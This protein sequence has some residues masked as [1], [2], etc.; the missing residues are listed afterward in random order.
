MVWLNYKTGEI[1][2]IEE[3]C[4]N[5][6]ITKSQETL[7][8]R[9]HNCMKTD[10]LYRGFYLIKFQRESPDDGDIYVI[11]MANKF[12][13]QVTKKEL[14]FLLANFRLPNDDFE[15]DFWKNF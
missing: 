11:N 6:G 1:M 12:K 3:K 9:V 13:K 14:L 5:S 8:M 2:L 10:P 15:L 7:L 4:Q